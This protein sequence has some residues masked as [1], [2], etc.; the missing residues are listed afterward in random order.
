MAT[1]NEIVAANRLR[2]LQ[3]TEAMLEGM[4]DEM[5]AVVAEV[6]LMTAYQVGCLHGAATERLAQK[7]AQA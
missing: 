3:E 6:A 5:K 4:S 7:Q 2:H 1:L